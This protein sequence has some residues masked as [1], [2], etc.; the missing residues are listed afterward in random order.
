MA[1]ALAGLKTALPEPLILLV[2][3]VD[4]STGLLNLAR[5]LKIGC[6]IRYTW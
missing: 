3:F 5:R 2:A 1:F 6:V 4:K